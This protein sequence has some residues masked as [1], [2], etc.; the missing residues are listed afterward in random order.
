MSFKGSLYSQ[1]VEITVTDSE[2]TL[3]FVYV[4]P[5]TKTKGEVVSR[6]TLPR[7]TGKGLAETILN[8]I[9]NHEKQK[10]S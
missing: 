9:A 8:T 2:I 1:E 6:I 4:N 7:K 5:R 3:E 10:K